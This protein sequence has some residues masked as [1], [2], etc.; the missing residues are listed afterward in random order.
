MRTSLVCVALA[1]AVSLAAAAVDIRIANVDSCL[2]EVTYSIE[3]T[4]P[5]FGGERKDFTFPSS[6]FDFAS[7][8]LTVVK[9]YETESG[10]ELDWELVPAEDNAKYPAVEL[11]YAHSLG[12]TTP[13]TIVVRTKTSNIS[14]DADGRCVIKYTTGQLATFQV[15]T[16]HRLVYTNYPVTLYERS[17]STVAE[18]PGTS[19]SER[20]ELIFKTRA[21]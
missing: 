7:G 16:G 19:S 11:H 2:M 18:V 12:K 17:G 20:K 6:G 1:A 9:A 3:A 4:S 15:P 8:P 21:F 10:K 13:T 14:K 5:L